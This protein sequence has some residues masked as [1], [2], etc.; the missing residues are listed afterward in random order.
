M[1]IL[2]LTLLFLIPCLIPAYSEDDHDHDHESEAEHSNLMEQL[3]FGL[4]KVEDRLIAGK[5]VTAIPV[6]AVFQQKG[7][8]FV[9]AEDE[10]DHHN[11]TRWEVQL[12]K[13]DGQFVEAKSGVF[14]GDEVV[15]RQ[16]EL[17][18]FK[19]E[20]VDQTPPAEKRTE[21]RPL[22]AKTGAFGVQIGAFSKEINARKVADQL[23]KA[24]GRTDVLHSESG[25]RS[26]YR[27]RVG[28][29]P[30]LST[31]KET[32]EKLLTTGYPGAF[33]VAFN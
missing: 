24:Y 32:R 25:E 16:R 6:E 27:V 12:G 11:F 26:L 22:P 7:T 19:I 31:A 29:Y 20:K 28:E 15:V 1:R 3:G 13:S 4:A 9:I 8:T 30:T 23:K 5:E 33:V 18:A 14:P 21:K 17:L 2:K 10:D